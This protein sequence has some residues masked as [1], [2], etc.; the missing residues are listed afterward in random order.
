MDVGFHLTTKLSRPRVAR[1]YVLRPHLST[2][3]NEGLSRRFTAL[4]A[5]AGHGKTSTL[6]HFLTEVNV[7]HLWIQLDPSDSDITSFLRYLTTGIQQTLQGGSRLLSALNSERPIPDPLPLLIADLQDITSSHAIV[8]DDFHL[9]DK[10]SP[11]IQLISGLLQYG[12]EKTHLFICSR[13]PLPFSTARFKVMQEAAEI[14]EEELRF[15]RPEIKTFFKQ[16]AGVDLT[17]EQLD[18]VEHLTEGWSAA[19]VLLA[20]GLRRPGGLEAILNGTLPTDLFAYLAEEVFRNLSPNLQSFMEE[21]SILEVLTPTACDDILSRRDS[22]AMISQLLNSN[23]LLVQIGAESFRYHHLF[24]RFL[25]ERLKARELGDFARLTKQAGDWFLDREEHEEAVK[26]YLL[27]GWLHEAAGL[28]EG[29]APLWLLRYRLERLRNLLRHLP[30]TLKDQYPW[31][32]VAEARHFFYAGQA[33]HAIGKARIALRSFTEYNDKRGLVHAH[34]LLGEFFTSRNEFDAADE[35]L[36]KAY[37]HLEPGFPFEEAMLLHK[38]AVL[39]YMIDQPPETVEVDLRRALAH[40]VELGHLS[41]E[42]VVSD[43]IGIVRAQSGDYPSAIQHLERA[44]HLMRSMGDPIHEVGLNLAWAYAE[45]GRFQDCVTILE[46]IWTS[47]ARRMKRVYAGLNLLA[48]YTRLGEFGRAI[49]LAPEV[50]AVVEEFGSPEVKT[51]LTLALAALYRLS[52]QSQASLPF[53]NEA[54]Q[55]VR[56]AG[57]TL[58][59]AKP[60]VQAVLLHLFYTNNSSR[61]AKVAERALAKAEKSTKLDLLFLT[62][63][64]AVAQFRLARTES[65]PE[66]A[67]TLQDGL[68]ECHRRGLDFFALHEWPL[69]L[70]VAIYGLAFDV[71]TELCLDLVRLM[72]THLP[73]TILQMGIPV[74]EPEAKFL[75]AAWQALPDEEARACFAALLTEQDRKRLVGLAT[76]PSPIRIQ[77]LGPLVVTIGESPVDVKALKKRK[78]GQLLVL[79]LTAEGPTPRE[80]LMDQLWPDLDPAAA[81]TSLRVSLHHLRRLLEPHLGGKQKSRYIQSEGG[82]LWFSREPE[83]TIDLD[84]FG[85]AIKQA[86]EARERKNLKAAASQYETA[87]RLYAGDLAADDPYALEELRESWRTAYNSALDWLAEYYWKEA[88]DPAR[89]IITLQRRLAADGCHEPAHQAL[90]RLYMETGQLAKARQQYLTCKER[91]ASQLG[92]SPGR[93]TESLLQRIIALETETSS[94]VASPST[95]KAR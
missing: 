26:Q 69:G 31:I 25:Q 72:Q 89:A 76:G 64:L 75:P 3:L 80:R 61:A 86:I 9:I 4:V 73:A 5:T 83:V 10:D 58:W 74:A 46:R 85:A 93:G 55:I 79:L 18:K 7:P 70:A 81:D 78:S 11:V 82:L 32:S 67:R 45:V 13:T 27:G 2:M 53:A 62:L 34:I 1:F 15:T 14:G 47:S 29:I 24:Q 39:A 35:E 49:T 20:S 63:G 91:L 12:G 44:T 6:S 94:T 21:S 66:A 54:L 77:G 16:S 37:E 50:N 43:L 51:S 87:V 17:D 19:L 65:R 22:A 71:Q 8:F 36:R 41:G 30:C 38:R 23:L 28:V 92:V 84:Q 40:F 52:G 88:Q 90:M 56:E 48:A 95:K 33:E 59:Q 68:T 42:A 57:I 60:A